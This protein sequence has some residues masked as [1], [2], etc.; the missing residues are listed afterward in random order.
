MSCLYMLIV[1]VLLLNLLIAFM[2]DSYAT[3]KA[4]GLAQW[5]LEQARIITEMEVLISQR[6]PSFFII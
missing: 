6:V 2:G 4:R 1:S 5:K 3:V